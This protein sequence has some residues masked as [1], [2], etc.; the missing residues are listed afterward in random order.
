AE[1]WIVLDRIT[2][3]I[4][5]FIGH[6][7][8]QAED[9]RERQTYDRFSNEEKAE[10][11][12]DDLQSGR[13]NTDAHHQLTG[14]DPRVEW[15]PG[16][17]EIV[18]LRAQNEVAFLP[19]PPA[20]PPPELL[21]NTAS[22]GPSAS[23]L[24][25]N[26]RLEFDVPPYLPGSIALVGVQA[27]MLIDR[28]AVQEQGSVSV[29][30][31]EF[32][33]QGGFE[34][35]AP[36]ADTFDFHSDFAPP[37][38]E[39][40]IGDLALGFTATVSA[41]SGPDGAQMS[42]PEETFIV[43]GASALEGAFVNGHQISSDEFLED[44]DRQADDGSD[45]NPVEEEETEGHIVSTGENVLANGLRILEAGTTAPIKM[46]AGDYTRLD[47]ITQYNIASDSNFYASPQLSD[48]ITGMPSVEAINS[49]LIFT[50]TGSDNG[51]QDQA[52]MALPVSWTVS[53][54]DGNLVHFNWAEQHNFV[55]D[56]DIVSKTKFGSETFLVTGSN[57]SFNTMSIQELSYSYDL[58][59]IS[60]D[61]YDIN[62]IEQHNLLND[63]DALFLM[64]RETDADIN[65]AT[66]ELTN[67][68]LIVR[69][70][71]T[72]FA[73]LTDEQS[74]TIAAISQGSEQLDPETLAVAANGFGHLNV[75]HISGSVLN[76]NYVQQ[77]NRLSD[78][79]QIEML[80]EGS[81][82]VWTIESGGNVLANAATIIDASL[83]TDAYVGGEAYSDAL[84]LQ[85]SLLETEPLAAESVLTSEAFVFLTEG[86]LTTSEVAAEPHETT[87]PADTSVPADVM[88]TMLA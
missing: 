16:A 65:G 11:E 57:T 12:N 5:Y 59:L 49:A 74:E 14:F 3:T 28:D 36:L 48:E 18:E 25:G 77:T 42:L 45:S 32:P 27:T 55:V 56:D 17:N 81:D 41:L 70:G 10:T 66:N 78:A 6:F 53:R 37:S 80:L 13:V 43:H 38:S 22:A 40:A 4:A 83:D 62:V 79:D 67:D 21:G 54:L 85:A 88:Q 75:L 24:N 51:D 26:L 34:D 72:E 9:L 39:E 68:A 60:N 29:F 73:A 61:V 20:S 86:M 87:Q 76:L 23:P 84:I 30:G 63:N 52:E 35:L 15:A 31:E 46:V 58:I 7:H 71:T 33:L 50:E 69:T 47:L 2:E 8:L 19:L 82:D 1:C 44:T 64:G